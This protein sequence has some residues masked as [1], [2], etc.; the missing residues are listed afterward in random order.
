MPSIKQIDVQRGVNVP[1]GAGGLTFDPLLYTN[2][3]GVATL[4]APDMVIPV[5][6]A[7]A[8]S[9]ASVLALATGNQQIVQNNAGDQLFDVLSIAFH[10]IQKVVTGD[11]SISISP[12][13]PPSPLPVRP[14]TP[15]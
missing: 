8:T 14:S 12:P 2:V 11:G 9:A 6:K 7:G 1:L 13:R 5:P 15:S 4:T 10:T 3:G